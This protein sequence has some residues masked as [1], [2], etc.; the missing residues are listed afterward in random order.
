MTNSRPSATNGPRHAATFADERPVGTFARKATVQVPATPPSFVDMVDEW[1][2]QSFP[3]SD[4]P[5][6]W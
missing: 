5:S 2:R 3:A 6:N 1:G 4:P